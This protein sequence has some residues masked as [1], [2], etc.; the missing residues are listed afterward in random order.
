MSQCVK[1]DKPS[2]VKC[3]KCK[4]MNYCSSDCQMNDLSHDLICC[5][6]SLSERYQRVY[7]LY[8]Q[9]QTTIKYIYMSSNNH[10]LNIE[11]KNHIIHPFACSSTDYLCVICAKKI[12]Y[13]GPKSNVKFVFYNKGIEI[14]CYR[15]DECNKKDK[16]I[17]PVTFIDAPNI[18]FEKKM[19]CFLM[20]VDNMTFVPSDVKQIICNLATFLKC[21]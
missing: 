6:A 17:C 10:Y 7:N 9:S 4:Y 1:C 11:G 15:C 5:S 3:E 21:C 19:L 2:L 8:K 14:N 13:S 16:R 12:T 18:C 20:C